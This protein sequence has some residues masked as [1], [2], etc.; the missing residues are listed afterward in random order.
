MAKAWEQYATEMYKRFGYLATWTPGVPLKLGDF[1]FIKDKLFTRVDNIGNLGIDFRI[2]EDTTKETQKHSTSGSVSISFKA[3][4]KAPQVGS[5]STDTE[6]GFTI[7]FKRS[8][9][10]VYE[11]LGCVAPSIEN[12]VEVGNEILKR[13]RE[14]AWNKDWVVI[15]ELVETA[16]ATVLISNSSNSKIELSVSGKVAPG[17]V[18]LADVSAGLQVAFSRDMNTTLISQEGL[19]PLFKA[20]GIKSDGP[21]GPFLNSE[22]ISRFNALDFESLNSAV[23]REDLVFDTVTYNLFGDEEETD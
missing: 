9:S 14:G 11:A 17:A 7:E 15:T 10:T 22:K 18:S 20:R 21:V 8:K 5:V 1:G 3:A 23:N 16:S 19:T 13:F 4:G 2:R 6:A 12:Q